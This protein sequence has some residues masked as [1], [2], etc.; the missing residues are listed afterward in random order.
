MSRNGSALLRTPRF[1]P[2]RDRHVPVKNVVPC[3]DCK[4]PV[5]V[6][7]KKVDGTPSGGHLQHPS[8]RRMAVRADNLARG[9]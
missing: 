5:K 9:L 3:P 8:R 6:A 7:C 1:Q 4:A 2:S